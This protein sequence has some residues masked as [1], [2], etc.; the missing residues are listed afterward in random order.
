TYWYGH[1]AGGMTARLINYKPGENLDQKGDP[2]IDGFLNDDSGGGLYLPY[3]EESGKNILFD[4]QEARQQFIRTIEIPHQLFVGH[5]G[6]AGVPQWI[7]PAYLT[8]HRIT[9]RILRDKGLGDKLRMYEIQG[10]SHIGDEYLEDD[11]QEDVAAIRLSRLMDGL[12]ELLDQWVENDISPPATRSDLLELGDLNG[13][14]INENPAVALPEVA[15]PLG[16][17]HPYPPSLGE[18]G[19]NWTTF[20]PFDGRTL[21]PLDGRGVFVDMNLNRY[22]DS[23]E[24]VQEAWYRLGLLKPGQSFNRE[25]YRACIQAAV[26][27]LTDSRFLTE[28]AADLY[29]QE[30]SEIDFPR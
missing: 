7:S 1:S 2:I 12:I 9:A 16:V 22:L 21:E 29:L 3:V 17:Y 19:V 28:Q 4:S 15:C 23:R 26:S 13:D 18:R 11:R 27:R 10:I 24:S 25:T 8:N 6:S 5:W 20:S 30:A 14:G